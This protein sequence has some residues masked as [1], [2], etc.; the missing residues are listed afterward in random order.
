MSCRTSFA[1]VIQAPV[2]GVALLELS[3]AQLDDYFSYLGV[4]PQFPPSGPLLVPKAHLCTSENCD[5]SGRMLPGEARLDERTAAWSLGA[6]TAWP[7]SLAAFQ[8]PGAPLLGSSCSVQLAH[9]QPVPCPSF[10]CPYFKEI[11]PFHKYF[12]PHWEGICFAF[13]MSA[14]SY[15]NRTQWCD[16]LSKCQFDQVTPA[17]SK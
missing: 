17:Q 1:P 2:S 13:D 12:L 10:H 5:H 6:C 7:R 4:S 14:N 16:W 3:L 8:P 9:L 11:A 15:L